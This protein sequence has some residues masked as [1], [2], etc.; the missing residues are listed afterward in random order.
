LA[1]FLAGFPKTLPAPEPIDVLNLTRTLE[2]IKFKLREDTDARDAHGQPPEQ[3]L[4]TVRALLTQVLTR[5]TALP[6]IRAAA[7]LERLQTFLFRDLADKWS[8]LQGSLAPA[9]PITLADVPAQ[10]RSRFVSADGQQFLL[11]IYPRYNIWDGA[12]LREFVNQL[13]QVDPDVTGNP[14]IGY[15]SIHAIKDGYAKGGL[16]AALAI[17]LVTFFALRRVSDT[18]RVLAP[19]GCGMLWTAGLMWLCHLQFNL[20][21]LVAVPLLI[22]VG[23]DGGINLIR[24]AREEARPGWRLIGE[25]TGQAMALYSLDSIVG[26]GSLLIAR[27]A[28]IFS[29][30][31]LLVL[32][33]SAVLLS[34]FTVLPLLLRA[35]EVTEVNTDSTKAEGRKRQDLFSPLLRQGK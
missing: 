7:A 14:V 2:R 18:L 29:M 31:L 16:Y 28:G 1:S 30:G 19:V 34:T 26:F 8:V 9:G 17:P 32:A 5:L 22:G 13:R 6:E 20:A 10:L 4:V 35:P 25:S 15:E 3:D 12:P 21:N 23:V 27:H 24:R 33:M 11:Q